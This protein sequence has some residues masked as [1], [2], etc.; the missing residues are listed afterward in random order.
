[1]SG[2]ARRREATYEDLLALPD[3]VL[4]QLV[5]GDLHATPR[6]AIGHQLSVSML[7]FELGPP[8]H[9]G[10]G[11][12]GGWWIV[13]EPEV[14]LGRNVLVPDLAGWRRERLPVLPQEAF[15][16]LAPDW[17]C[18]V[19]SPST[20]RLDRLKKLAIYAR[21]GVAHAWLLDPNIETLEVYRRQDEAWLLVLTA[22][23][24]DIVR[25]EPFDAIELTLTGL[26]IRP[27]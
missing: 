17:A 25:A 22:G 21:E 4:G 14:H 8:F 18:E 6:P 9:T 10:R 1:M 23:G 2:V 5:E 13:D 27:A 26:W 20:A 15:F 19:L 3:D 7:G 24:D 11:G 12:P 16:T